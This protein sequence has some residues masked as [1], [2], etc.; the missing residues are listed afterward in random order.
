MNAPLLLYPIFYPKPEA[1][2]EAESHALLGEDKDFVKRAEAGEWVPAKE[3]DKLNEERM[4]A[5]KPFL[6]VTY[7][8]YAQDEK[9][10]LNL[11]KQRGKSDFT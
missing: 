6:R 4:R 3:L 8:T 9:D 1:D 2:H 11:L 7:R 5:G 10:D